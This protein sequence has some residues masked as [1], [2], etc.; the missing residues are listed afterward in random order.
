MPGLNLDA[1]LRK[2]LV[3]TA[4]GAGG[5][6]LPTPLASTFIDYVRDRNFLR[7]A[8]TVVPMESKTRDYPKVF[9]GTK[10]Y[11]QP[12]EGGSAR[13][14]RFNTGTLS[15]EAKKF[16]AEIDL[17]EEVIEDSAFDI[18]SI[19]TNHF[20][21][22][23]SAAEE[24]AM[25]TGNPAHATQSD[26]DTATEVNW[27][28]KDHR[29]IFYGLLPLAADIAGDI[30]L[31]TRAANRVNAGGAAL[32]TGILRQAIYNMGKYGR[33]NSDILGI[34][35][36]WSANELL[37]DPKLVTLDVYGANATIF[38]GE[39]GK[40]YNKYS[41]IQSP[42]C[43]DG[44]GVVTH[45]KNPIIGDRRKVRIKRDTD[46]TN[47]TRLYVITERIDFMVSYKGALVQIH[48]LNEPSD[49]S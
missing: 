35:N 8:F 4:G 5:D 10:V 24:E 17:S 42:Y 44:Y 33:M 6:F 21:D 25:L 39:F 27:Y 19:V 11:H 43:T 49:V 30:S 32:S 48:N 40:L 29:L 18:E 16:M 20:G 28:E 36:P 34:V 2:T 26:E 31:D 1:A 37:D 45:R 22:Q 3:S 47:D 38:T 13:T 46:I 12:T 41:M 15:L 7:Q 9:G 23:L 14:T